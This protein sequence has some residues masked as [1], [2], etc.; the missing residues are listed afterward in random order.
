MPTKRK[1]KGTTTKRSKVNYPVGLKGTDQR[2]GLEKFIRK[3]IQREKEK[4]QNFF[5]FASDPY[6]AADL[7]V[8]QLTDIATGTDNNSRIG[9]E[10]TGAWF[11]ILLNVYNKTNND[12]FVRI[13]LLQFDGLGGSGDLTKSTVCLL[14]PEG[15]AVDFQ[16]ATDTTLGGAY[17]A[18]VMYPWDTKGAVKI[19]RERVLK[20]AKNNGGDS[21]S[22]RTIKW[23]IPW[24][25]TIR[26]VN[27]TD[28]GPLKQNHRVACV[29]T[30]WSPSGGPQ[31]TY[32]YALDGILKFYYKD[33]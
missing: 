5:T 33:N 17:H 12:L 10:I 2:K 30:A 24:E 14:K 31:A 21:G 16:T 1:Y 19:L 28:Q 22:T 6:N 25:R 4:K 15:D 18:S 26:Y 13:S 11:E 32:T 3:T 8:A 7:V 20:I 29:V 9:N 23:N 27:S